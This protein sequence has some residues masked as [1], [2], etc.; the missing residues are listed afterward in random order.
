MEWII[1]AATIY[2]QKVTNPQHTKDEIL[3]VSVVSIQLHFQ[4][5]N[6]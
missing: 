6:L 2:K 3:N 4:L 1:E 5:T